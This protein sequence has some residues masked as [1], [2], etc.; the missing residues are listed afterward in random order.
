V[1]RGERVEHYETIRVAKDGRPI[2]VSLT[3]SPLIDRQGAVV[4]ASTIVHD[5]TQRKQAETALRRTAQDLAR[6]NQDLEQFAYV[7]SHDLLEPLRMVTGYLQLIER[8]YK[9]KLDNDAREFINFAVDGAIRMNRLITDLLDYSRI[10]TRGKQ[11]E[12]VAMES[13]LAR[14]LDYLQSAIRDSDAVITHDPL[15]TVQGDASQL[16]QLMQ[17]L[18]GNAIKFRAPERGARVCIGAQ[19]NDDE[20]V[21]SVKDEGIGIEP[22]YMEK[23]FLI[24]QR[25]HSRQEYPGTG[26]GL[27]ICK[28]IVERHGGRIWVQSEVGQGSTFFFTIGHT[29][30][31]R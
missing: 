22:Q 11:P 29:G 2:N 31:T 30:P 16:V 5:I 19:K 26:I 23:I 3:V 15:P 25:L 13:V 4:G 10:H 20:W 12:P 21:F 9:D 1:T 7:A 27:A 17:N 6:S 8:R 14:A 24:F 18:I 28:K